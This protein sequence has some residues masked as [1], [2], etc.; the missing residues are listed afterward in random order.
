MKRKV[1]I[2]RSTDPMLTRE[3][4]AM[5]QPI[6]FNEKIHCRELSTGTYRTGFFLIGEDRIHAELYSY[7]GYFHLDVSEPLYLQTNDNEIISL[8]QNFGL[9]EGDS[10][11]VGKPPMTVRHHKL[12]SNVAVIGRSQWSSVDRLKTVSFE[13]PHTERLL[14]HDKKRKGI[15]KRK[16]G[17][18]VDY[19]LFAVNVGENIVRAYYL[20]TY[21]WDFDRPKEILPRLEIEFGKGATLFE[22]LDEVSH[23]VSFFSAVV[24]AQLKPDKIEIQRLSKDEILAALKLRGDEY[25]GPHYVQYNWKALGPDPSNL[26]AEHPLLRAWDDEYLAALKAC[27]AAWIDRSEVWKP[28]NVLMMGCLARQREMSTDRL[29]SACTWFEQ[30]PTS[31][32]LTT[33]SS[34]DVDRITNCATAMAT[35]L[36][37]PSMDIRIRGSLSRLSEETRQDQFARLL[38]SV[39]EKLGHQSID[40]EVIQHLRQAVNFR[41]K[42]AHGHLSLDDDE[43]YRKFAKATYAME[44]FCFLLTVKDLPIGQKGIEHLG[45][46][47]FLQNYRLS[48]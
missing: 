45:Q 37:H 7:D 22:Y 19:E 4:N 11:F 26:L 28:A 38:N 33:I 31:K 18:E 8:H 20:A 30:I 42:A 34:D 23:V 5:S 2:L 29:I 3:P 25:I 9:S 13:I 1:V 35:E 6:K 21:S 24:A 32:P 16:L 17:D 12:M 27:L 41:G 48:F 40:D 43:Q 46:S 44:A 10:N 15:A 14:R 47:V 36:G 39:R